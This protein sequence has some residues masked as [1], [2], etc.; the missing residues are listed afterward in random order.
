MNSGTISHIQ[1]RFNRNSRSYDAHAYVQRSMADQLAQILI[2]WKNKEHV[3][4]PDILEVGCGTGALTQ[5]L[6]NEWPGAT[7][8]ALDLA[9][10]MIKIA[11]KRICS[12]DSQISNNH[13]KPDHIRFIH[14]DIEK[15]SADA[16]ASCF[17]II[18]S[19]ACFQWLSDPEQTLAQLQRM[20]R[21][22]GIL[23]FSTFGP[24]TFCEMHKSF[25][26][27]YRVH[28]MEPQRHGLSFHSVVQWKQMLEI[29]GYSTVHHERSI[30]MEKYASAR[31]F[32]YSVKAMGA[33]ASE[34]EPGAGKRLRSL[35]AS[36]YEEY[37]KNYSLPG[38]IAVTYELLYIQAS[39]VNV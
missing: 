39:V 7:F 28:G 12:T 11:K 21:P 23:L 2:E 34:A 3:E 20:L 16:P 8:T 18:I 37:E 5:I 29:S 1:S 31:D 4:M 6:T 36:M 27:A 30:Y 17:H 14:A 24:V 32:L 38:G 10:E 33:S 9:P 35:F 25:E 22:G 13:C 26:H 15:W 19:N